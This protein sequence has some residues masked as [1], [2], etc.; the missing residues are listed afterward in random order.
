MLDVRRLK[1]WYRSGWL[2]VG[3]WTVA[4]GAGDITDS[5]DDGPPLDFT[6]TWNPSPNMGGPWGHDGSP[7]VSD[8]PCSHDTSI[9]RLEEV[10][11][12]TEF[13]TSRAQGD[14]A[15]YASPVRRP[16]LASSIPVAFR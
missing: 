10:G 16:R 1:C 9:D 8:G 14:L 4:C 5:P 7:V 11:S 6:G 12:M 3:L 15:V 2:V 13:F